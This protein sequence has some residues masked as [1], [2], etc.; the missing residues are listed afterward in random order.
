MYTEL[1]YKNRQQCM[2][3]NRIISSLPPPNLRLALLRT[4][5]LAP[6]SKQFLCANLLRPSDRRAHL[7]HRHFQSPPSLCGHEAGRAGSVADTLRIASG[8]EDG[9]SLTD[10]AISIGRARRRK[11]RIATTPIIAHAV[12]LAAGH[13]RVAKALGRAAAYSCAVIR[14][15]AK[16]TAE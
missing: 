16:W 10:G 5:T 11:T 14:L 1:A 12:R 4:H 6:T 15:V 3:L 2:Y 9:T 8:Y 7:L 13:T